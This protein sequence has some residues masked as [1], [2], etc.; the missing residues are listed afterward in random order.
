M[1]LSMLQRYYG[2]R[3]FTPQPNNYVLFDAFFDVVSGALPA[4]S[5]SS[6]DSAA[7]LPP[8][9]PAMLPAAGGVA[10]TSTHPTPRH[11]YAATPSAPA[12]QLPQQQPS[13]A[14]RPP[15]PQPTASSA[16]PQPYQHQ[17]RDQQAQP[18]QLVN[19]SVSDAEAAMFDKA[20]SHRLG[21]SQRPP[22]YPPQISHQ[23]LRVSADANS[24]FSDSLYQQQHQQQSVRHQNLSQHQQV[25]R[26]P[27][28]RVSPYSHPQ[29][30]SAV[31][32]SESPFASSSSGQG[33]AFP[34][35]V[36]SSTRASS[37]GGMAFSAAGDAQQQQQHYGGGHPSLAEHVR[38]LRL[39][40]APATSDTLRAHRSTPSGEAGSISSS[41][42][43]SYFGGG[44]RVA[45]APSLRRAPMGGFQWTGAS[46]EGGSSP[47][48]SSRI[49][50]S[51]GGGASAA[52]ILPGG[53]GGQAAPGVGG[54]PLRGGYV[55]GAPHSAPVPPFGTAESSRDGVLSLGV[56][57]L[58]GS[59]P[60]PPSTLE[61]QD[62]QSVLAA[63]RRAR[64]QEGRP[65]H[66]PYLR[67]GGVVSPSRL[68]APYY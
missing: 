52:S 47:F 46:Q 18:A 62:Q 57:P 43:S 6:G 22:S 65:Q 14:A 16:T 50:S 36:G 42:S 29:G 28:S 9:A 55:A 53:S 32:G 15:T 25:P 37:S 34:N 19:F 49:F 12:S 24:G 3:A 41:S 45:S 2:L 13:Q 51:A 30:G 27:Y 26:D 48:D 11:T 17:R 10:P 20:Q 44:S 8:P 63:A 64:L 59:R 1:F 35:R 7:P 54:R 56:A 31:P 66:D 5:S 58:P 68:S 60:P 21:S 4:I 23:Q 61:L 33:G 38:V 67:G 39:S 40:A